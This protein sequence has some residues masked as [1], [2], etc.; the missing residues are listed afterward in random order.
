MYITESPCCNSR[1]WCNS[2]NQL[3]SDKKF[4]KKILNNLKGKIILKIQVITPVLQKFIANTY[5]KEG[6]IKFRSLVTKLNHIEYKYSSN[7]DFSVM[8]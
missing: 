2:V 4:L 1:D 7:K 5:M 6:K 3:Y 8:N